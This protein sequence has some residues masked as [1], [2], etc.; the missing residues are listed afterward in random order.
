[1]NN[2][3]LHILFLC[4]GCLLC[5]CDLDLKISNE[6]TEDYFWADYEMTTGILTSVYSEYF[7][8]ADAWDGNFLDAATDNAMTRVQS[9]SVFKA[10]QGGITVNGN[11]LGKWDSY[12]S[13]LQRIHIFMEQGVGD[14]VLYDVANQENDPIIENRLLGEAHF[15]RAYTYFC[16]LREYGGKTAS[17]EALGVPLVT[18]FIDH[19][20]AAATQGLRRDSYDACVEQIVSNCDKAFEMLPLRYNTSDA[21]LGQDNYGRASGISAAALKLR[22]LVYA[23]SPAVQ[24]DNIVRLDGPGQFTVVDESAYKAKWARAA[25]YGAEVIGLLGGSYTALKA[26]DLYN[27]AEYLTDEFLFQAY[28]G[29]NHNYETRHFPPYYYGQAQTT[30]SHNL[31]LAFPAKNGYPVTDPRSG[32]DPSDP[33]ACARDSRFDVN[34]FYQGR[35]FGGDK[36]GIDVSEGGKDSMYE[37]PYAT[38]TG[39]YLGKFLNTSSS[40][41]LDPNATSNSRHCY[42]LLRA[43]EV[44]LN[45]AEAAFEAWGP[46]KAAEGCSWTAYDV[47]K[48]TRAKSGGITDVTYLDECAASDDAFRALL[49][50]ERRIELAF[51]NQRYWDMRRWLLP[52][53]ETVT[54]MRITRGEDGTLTYA[55]Q[56]VEKRPL[57]AVRYY[58]FPIPKSETLKTS[59]LVNNIGW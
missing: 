45:Y 19:T 52:L 10:G 9:S 23:A 28:N 35:V 22:A 54:G 27:G 43:G 31:A 32:Y 41:F 5:S 42:P 4:A 33:Y 13:Q 36:A 57:D 58:Y 38:R 34:L 2:K 46:K 3:Y 30:P 56:D 59:S 50:N 51:E 39:Y 6:W 55:V 44:W 11:P 48:T 1:M 14:H 53:D 47:L 25:Q 37:S 18:K 24:P 7:S 16:L 26:A 15:L 17:G 8:Y 12:Y 21:I 29:N 40:K 49:Q 20:D